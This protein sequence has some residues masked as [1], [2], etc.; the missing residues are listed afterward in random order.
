MPTRA[1]AAIIALRRWLDN[2]SGG[3]VPFPAHMQGPNQVL[4]NLDITPQ[5][6]MDR[7]SQHVSHCTHCKRALARTQATATATM[8]AAIASLVGACL[9]ASVRATASLAPSTVPGW[10]LR[11]TNAGCSLVGLPGPLL[12]LGLFAIGVH[13]VAKQVE[14][15]FYYKDFKRPAF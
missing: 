10:L 14:Q 8:A 9:A 12:L 2:Y 5:Q 6:A 13:L 11:V 7:Y 15:L 3:Q 4:A 1:D